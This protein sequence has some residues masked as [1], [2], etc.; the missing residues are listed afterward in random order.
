MATATLP[1]ML[2]EGFDNLRTQLSADVADKVNS[3]MKGFEERMAE[4]FAKPEEPDAPN[5]NAQR[6]AHMGELIQRAEG[7]TSDQA[8]NMF[9]GLIRAVGAAGPN[10]GEGKIK[11]SYKRFMGSES[12]KRLEDLQNLERAYFDEVKTENRA[13]EIAT[14]ANGG[15]FATETMMAAII[16][17]LYPSA[18]LSAIGIAPFAMGSNVLKWAKETAEGVAYWGRLEPQNIKASQGSFGEF[19]LE[20]RS[21]TAVTSF[22]NTFL[23]AFGNVANAIA[24][25]RFVR[26]YSKTMDLG[27][28]Y[29]DG[30]EDRPFGLLKRAAGDANSIQWL[31]VGALPTVDTP[32]DFLIKLMESDATMGNLQWVM[33]PTLFGVLGKLR[34]GNGNPYFPELRNKQ[35]ML[36]GYPVRVST[37]M[38]VSAAS[39][40]PADLLVG[41]WDRYLIGEYQPLEIFATKEGAYIDATGT[42]RSTVS[43]DET[44]VRF[45]WQGDMAPEDPT[46]FIGSTDVWTSAS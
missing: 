31:S 33:G 9:G 37:T 35:P 20:A 25:R 1:D 13:Y 5:P 42:I 40:K 24:L 21:L 16:P 18:I 6:V 23:K 17:M 36:L 39:H 46:C 28:I 41:D 8:R 38:K 44:A 4:R 19:R 29:G 10:A 14:P 30:Q 11:D 45:I 34:D 12:L 27:G 15:V 22:T 26:L 32:W 3:A 7:L 43:N 2:K